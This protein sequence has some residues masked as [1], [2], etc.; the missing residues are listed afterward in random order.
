MGWQAPFLQGDLLVA[1]SLAPAEAG[2]AFEG[3]YCLG[4]H[5]VINALTVSSSEGC[6]EFPGEPSSPVVLSGV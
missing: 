6:R 2:M 3:L 1:G 4:G 5:F